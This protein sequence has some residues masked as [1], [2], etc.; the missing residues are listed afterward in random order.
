MRTCRLHPEG[1]DAFPE[2]DV[3][4]LA[5]AW[6]TCVNEPEEGPWEHASDV[7]RANARAWAIELAREYAR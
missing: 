1:C 4:R 2:L 5:Q 6:W 7:D 3:E